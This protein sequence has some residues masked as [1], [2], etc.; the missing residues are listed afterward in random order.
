[1]TLGNYTFDKFKKEKEKTKNLSVIIF[2]QYEKLIKSAIAK[3][4]IVS[5]GIFFTKD[6][7]NE[8]P[9]S[10]RPFELA[11]IIKAKLT[12]AGMK[13][14]VFDEKKSRKEIW[15][16]CWRLDREVMQSQDLFS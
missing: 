12:N 7:Q 6:L 15:A 14:S 13:V 3:N 8:P 5:E 9:S 2:A 10:L 4:N 1:M 16:D 11:E